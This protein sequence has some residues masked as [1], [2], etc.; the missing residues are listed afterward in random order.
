MAWNNG[1]SGM[2]SMGNNMTFMHQMMLWVGKLPGISKQWLGD[3]G[4]SYCS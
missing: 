3:L 1:L 4:A 2:E